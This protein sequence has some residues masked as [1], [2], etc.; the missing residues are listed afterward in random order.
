MCQQ[1]PWCWALSKDRSFPVRPIHLLSLHKAF[2]VIVF[3]VALYRNCSSLFA[4]PVHF[5][6]PLMQSLIPA[7]FGSVQHTIWFSA[8]VPLDSRRPRCDAFLFVC[9][10]SSTLHVPTHRLPSLILQ[11]RLVHY[12]PASAIHPDRLHLTAL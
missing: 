11:V 3:F 2:I 6:E 1:R 5:H 10:F 8:L 7:P 4:F 9:F 12:S